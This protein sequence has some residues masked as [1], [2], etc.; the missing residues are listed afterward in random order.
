MTQGTD[1]MGQT[2]CDIFITTKI[3]KI[4]TSSIA[5]LSQDMFSHVQNICTASS[6]MDGLVVSED[7]L[8]RMQYKPCL[9]T[10]AVE[11]SVKLEL[12]FE[13]GFLPHEG[14]QILCK[15]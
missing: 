5:H 2:D 13:F 11:Q 4:A 7:L 6:G 8:E 1:N 15:F 14:L 10:L 9:P 12:L 3:Y